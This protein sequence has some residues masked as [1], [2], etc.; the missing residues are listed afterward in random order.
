MGFLAYSDIHHDHY[1]NGLL[2][3]DTISVEDQITQYAVDHNIS[4]VFFLG[5]WYR[6]TNPLQHVIKA[7]ESSWKRRCDLGIKTIVL[8][9]NHDRDTKSATSKH[10]FTAADIFNQDLNGVMVIDE[11]CVQD[12]DNIPFLFIPSGHERASLDMDVSSINGLVVLFHG[13]LAGSALVNGGHAGSGINP[14]LLSQFNASLVLGGDN[15]THQ[16]L[17]NLLGCESM[18]LGAPLQHNWGDRGQERGFWHFELSNNGWTYNKVFATAPRF[19]RFNV[20]AKS[21]MEALINISTKVNEDLGEYP[22]I[23]EI[24][25]INSND[26]NLDYIESNIKNMCNIRSIKLIVDKTF[27]KLEVAAGI[28]E[29]T[30]PEE[31]WDLY[32]SSNNITGIEDFDITK[33]SNIGKWAIQEAK[34]L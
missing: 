9:G 2:L 3:E 1:T 19:L 28:T 22:G 12:I 6:A 13:L 32:V 24:T 23:V 7:A 10:A 18:Y 14:S 26:I 17:D 16:R 8:V 30:S 29:A 25:L 31:K 15:H 4:T 33:L 20:E 34:K 11:P 21:E 5:D 27:K